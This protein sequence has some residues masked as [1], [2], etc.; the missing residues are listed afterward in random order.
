M[1]VFKSGALIVLASLVYSCYPGGSI[2]IEDLDTVTTLFEA[3]DFETPPTS[4]ALSMNVVEV[5]GGD[6]NDIPYNGEVDDEILQ[7]TYAQLVLL[8]GK[9]SVFQVFDITDLPLVEKASALVIPNIILREVIV[10]TVYPG[11][12]WGWGG[13]YG[14]C[15]YCY[16]PPYVSYEKY[17]GGAIVLDMYDLDVV[18][19]AIE[20]NGGMVPDDFDLEPS[21]VSKFSGLISSNSSFNAERV[22]E[23]I[24]QGFSQSPY[25]NGNK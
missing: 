17:E 24:V 12:G 1:P 7:T 5:K 2:P 19:K 20:D 25:L 6:D 8:Y 3:E 13:W 10:G 18:R 16:N 15:Y 11:W 21:W 9:D 23:G 22:T 4:V 14:G